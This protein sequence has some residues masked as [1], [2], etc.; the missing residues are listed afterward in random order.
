MKSAQK[1]KFNLLGDSY[2]RNLIPVGHIYFHAQTRFFLYGVKFVCTQNPGAFDTAKQCKTEARTRN[3]Q[4]WRNKS[5]SRIQRAFHL[6]NTADE[7][8]ILWAVF[9]YGT[10]TTAP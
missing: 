10:P 4:F 5:R 1:Y 7:P 6:K 2:S 8:S 9:Q 3:K